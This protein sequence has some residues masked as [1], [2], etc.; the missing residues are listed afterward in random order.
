MPKKHVPKSFCRKP[1]LFLF[2]PLRDLLLQLH[3]LLRTDTEQR[4]R[5]HEDLD[6][7]YPASSAGGKL[8]HHDREQH[9]DQDRTAHR[10]GRSCRA[11]QYWSRQSSTPVIDSPNSPIMAFFYQNFLKTCV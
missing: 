5:D 9:I 4:Q 1:S 3:E 10:V 8:A 7:R 2:F 6:R 11:A